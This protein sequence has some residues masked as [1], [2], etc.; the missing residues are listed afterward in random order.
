MSPLFYRIVDDTEHPTSWWLDEVKCREQDIDSR[1]LTRG[2]HF[3]NPSHLTVDVRRRGQPMQFSFSLL[4]VPVVSIQLAEMIDAMAPG[5]V[6][7]FPID[8]GSIRGRYEVINVIRVIDVVDRD[9][10]VYNVWKPEDGR[11]DKLGKFR[12]VD[13]LVIK[14]DVRQSAGIFRPAGWT[15]ALIVSA[16]LKK[17]L[18]KLGGLAVRFRPLEGGFNAN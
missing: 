6:E 15:V 5:A 9:R 16:V 3:E 11:S 2:E 10:S 7:R 17:E 8:V 18:E 4:F 12:G 14:D 1:A 13:R